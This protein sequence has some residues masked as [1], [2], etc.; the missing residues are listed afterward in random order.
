MLNYIGWLIRIPPFLIFTGVNATPPPADGFLL[1]TDET[2][3]LL[4][5]STFLILT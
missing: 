2:N 3:F 5:D 4:T 1:L